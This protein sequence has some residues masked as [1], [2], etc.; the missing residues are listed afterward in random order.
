MAVFEPVAKELVRR[1]EM[2]GGRI[3]AVLGTGL[4]ADQL[5][6]APDGGVGQ[7]LDHM[8]WAGEF[9]YRGTRRHRGT[10]CPKC[11]FYR[12]VSDDEEACDSY[13]Q[14]LVHPPVKREECGYFISG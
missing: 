12:C 5:N 3:E 2:Y 13:E 7:A 6:T 14:W 1:L 11:V 9:K 4:L 8:T 10:L